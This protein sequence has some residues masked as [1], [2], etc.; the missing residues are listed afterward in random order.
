MIGT[1]RTNPPEGAGMVLLEAKT[2]RVGTIW[3]IAASLVALA[4]L[5]LPGCTDPSRAHAVNVPHA[6]DALKIALD[7]WKN[8]GT[9][10]SLESASTPIIVQDLDWAGGAKLID[11][12]VLDDGKAEDANL[13]IQVKL[14]IGGGRPVNTSSK[15]APKK[16]W[17]L[18]GTSPKVTVF[19]DMLRR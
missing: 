5:L 4:C 1:A 10:K 14:N 11:Y 15:P 18:V 16:V 2:S 3:V 9:P 19:R 13:R 12:E 17:Y 8:G 7:E 6:R